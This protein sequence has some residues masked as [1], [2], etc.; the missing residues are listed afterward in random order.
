M[1]ARADLSGRVT[2]ALVATGQWL[3]GE[4]YQFI[5]PT[6]ATHARVLAREPDRRAR[7]LRDVFGWSRAFGGDLL[8][9]GIVESLDAAGLL[10]REGAGLRSK[11]RFSF[12]EGQLYAH[13]AYPTTQADAVFF[14]PDT[15]RFT[16][17]ILQELSRRPFAEGSA[18]R[19]LDVGC[20]GGAGGLVAAQASHA[21]SPSLALADINPRALAFAAANAAL[22][23]FHAVAFAA[24]DLYAPLE[25]GFDLIVSNPPY[26]NDAARRTYR[27]GGGRW[28]EALSDR[29]VREGLPRLARGGRLV[30]YTGV[31]IV[32]G[33][34]ALLEGLAPHLRECGWSWYYRELDPDV[35]GEELDS[36]AYA[37]VDR[38]AVTALVVERPAP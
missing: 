6:P 36:P 22:A 8:P 30:L 29:I 33:R 14:G 9:A 20:G 28:G 34:D 16:S 4:G 25:G 3:A 21:A 31:A 18:P 15:Y 11:V 37:E 35:F 5:A 38:I 13:S 17:L 24:G 26:L 12:L 10:D 1:N 23:D 32:D 7:D 19:L 2:D 27:H